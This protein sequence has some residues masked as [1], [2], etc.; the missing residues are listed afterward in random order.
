M[1]DKKSKL[2][3]R[4]IDEMMSDMDEKEGEK[5]KPRVDVMPVVE[6][7]EKPAGEMASSSEDVFDESNE[8]D[9]LKKLLKYYMEGNN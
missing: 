7:A 2:K 5:L 1:F 9:D 8:D 6:E 4:I 3:S